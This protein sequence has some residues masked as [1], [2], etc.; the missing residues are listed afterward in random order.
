MSHPAS[1]Q[2]TLETRDASPG[3][4]PRRFGWTLPA[5]VAVAALALVVASASYLV[6]QPPLPGRIQADTVTTYTSAV[7]DLVA[8]L[9]ALLTLGLFAGAALFTPA[10]PDGTVGS[11]AERLV[12]WSGRFGQLWFWSSA[13]L[14]AANTAFVNGVPMGYVLS[15]Q[16]WWTFQSVTPSGLAWLASALVALGAVLISFGTRR[17][18]AFA[19]WLVPGVLSLTFVA[20]TGNVTVGHNHDWATDAAIVASLTLVPLAAAAIG[21]FARCRDAGPELRAD[22]LRRYDRLALPLASVGLVAHAL[23]AWQ[24]LAGVSPLATAFG[25]PTLGFFACLVLLIVASLRRRIS[26]GRPASGGTPARAALGVDVAIWVAYTAF[27]TVA[28]H[29]PPPSFLIPQSIQI[30]YLGYEVP[31]PVT[32]TRLILPGR[33]NLL[34]LTLVIVCIGAYLAGVRR[35]RRSGGHWPVGRTISWGLGWLLTLFLATSGLW[36]YSTVVFSWH[37]F[38]HMTV[39]MLVPVLCL[40]GAP[41]TLVEAASA[42]RTTG[43]LPSASDLV[44]SVTEN[45]LVQLLLSPPLVWLAYVGSLFAI[46]YTPL[47]PWLMRYHWAHQLMLLLFMVTGYAFF[48]ML[49]GIDRQYWRMPHLIK[50]ALLISI[51]PFH[52]IFAVGILSSQSLIGADFYQAIDVAWVGNLMADQNVAGQITWILGEVPIVVVI[53]AL[54]TQW[55]RQDRSESTEYDLSEQET[56]DDQLHA[57]NDMLRE[58]AERDADEARR[59]RANEIGLK[60]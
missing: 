38:V 23:I 13:L 7:A 55:F 47:F 39:N 2:P 44:T 26:G 9:S 27:R 37:M 1:P 53:I 36:E 12:R 41:L 45:R 17:L 56:E 14:T 34:W 54:A 22:A 16:S 49:I 51:M 32:I 48:N 60:P 28:N 30:N 35:V 59:R 20:V 8:R 21:A 24:E 57:Y 58:L 15:P 52:A 6:G 5:V 11:S 50:L 46:Y 3:G 25:L 42:G 33:S 40:L 29:I 4:A 19:G 10:E 31:D 43:G 18:G